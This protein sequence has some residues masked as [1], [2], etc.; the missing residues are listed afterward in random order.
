MRSWM[1]AAAVS[2][3]AL[4]PAFA[5]E[6][7]P[8]APAAAPSAP[9]AKP[10]APLSPAEQRAKQLVDEIVAAFSARDVP[11][12]LSKA[13]ALRRITVLPPAILVLQARAAAAEGRALMAKH[14]Y[15]EYF[16]RAAPTD[17]FYATARTD[18]QG[19][20]TAADNELREEMALA[21]SGKTGKMERPHTDPNNPPVQPD[22][23]ADVRAAG[24][25]GRVVL[26]LFV[27]RD[28]R[29]YD[30]SVKTSSG[31][32]ALD[33]SALATALS[34]WRFV[35]GTNDGKPL[36]MW[37]GFAASFQPDD[38]APAAPKAAAPAAPKGGKK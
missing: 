16:L 27:G 8:A 22:Y 15:D 18:R 26:D 12:V 9:A 11:G 36:P 24:K 32:E 3:L 37:V 31:I 33:K 17:Q 38:K 23:P 29:I 28:G 7:K 6:T 2:V 1:M 25:G 5:A 4:A 30:A 19:I 21:L 20:A 34:A 14:L 35:P 10:A 13:E